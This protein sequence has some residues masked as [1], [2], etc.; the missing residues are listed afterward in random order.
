M[1]LEVIASA[2]DDALAAEAGGATR[3]EVV[4]HLDLGGLTPEFTLAEAITKRVRIPAR[5]MIRPRDTFALAGGPELQDLLDAIRH[6]A[7][8]PSDGLV[9]GYV[10]GD[11]V[12][13]ETLQ[14]VCAATPTSHITFHRA[15]DQCANP[16]AALRSL[17]Q[18]PQVDWVLTSGGTGDWAERAAYLARMQAQVASINV[19]AGGG[20]DEDAI[21]IVC[22]HTPLRAFHI[23][24]A[25]REGQ[26]V[27][28]RVSER[29]VAELR[30]RLDQYG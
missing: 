17:I 6:F 12:D 28:G 4:S 24:R 26:R 11:G 8:L 22:E 25:A 21:R 13:I 15:I 23:G 5:L 10:Q 29:K 14:E 16:L 7:Q 2:L 20:V 30:C 19:L 3:I 18:L 27:D 1:M 9:L